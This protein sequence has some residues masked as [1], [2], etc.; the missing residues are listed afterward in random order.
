MLGLFLG[1]FVSSITIPVTQSRFTG[2]PS[3]ANTSSIEQIYRID[4]KWISIA[5]AMI[6]CIFHFGSWGGFNDSYEANIGVQNNWIRWMECSL[7]ASLMIV[8]ISLFTGITSLIAQMNAF[9][10][11]F[12]VI[13]LLQSVEIVEWGWS[14]FWLSVM[15]TMLVWIGIFVAYGLSA[16]VFPW[17]VH[18]VVFSGLFYFIAI[19]A[20][21]A[22]NK[23][24]MHGSAFEARRL[25]TV[26]QQ[27]TKNTKEEVEAYKA[28][29]EPA[30][31]LLRELMDK[32]NK[33][34]TSVYVD[35]ELYYNIF[36]FIA[37][38]L[39]LWFT[40]IASN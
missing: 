12:M 38:S 9:A 26:L 24:A 39:V 8:Q 32:Q 40:F 14:A 2:S 13:W 5:I 16:S 25:W 37:K 20:I 35:G 33:D 10:T 17:F 6:S 3:Y 1:S 27:L 18:A 21:T 11:V 23:L 34:R 19:I 28:L 31:D 29:F 22:R 4:P 30:F 36:S 15:G 7:S